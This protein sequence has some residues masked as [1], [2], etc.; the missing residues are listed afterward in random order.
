[1][2]GKRCMSESVVGQGIRTNPLPMRKARLPELQSQRGAWA[3]PS[4]ERLQ[5]MSPSALA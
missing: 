5:P 2:P 1:M 3:H 4:E